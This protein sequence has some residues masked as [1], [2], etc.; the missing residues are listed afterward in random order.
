MSAKT[1]RKTGLGL[2]NWFRKYVLMP[3]V[4]VFLLQG[5]NVAAQDGSSTSAPGSDVQPCGTFSTYLVHFTPADRSHILSAPKLPIGLMFSRY[6]DLQRVSDGYDRSGLPMV[7][8]DGTKFLPAGP[9]DDLGLYFIVPWISR[10]LHI[11]LERAIAGFLLSALGLGFVVGSAGLL[12]GLRTTVVNVISVSVLLLLSGLAYWVGD[13]YIFEFASFAA[14]FPWIWYFMCCK[15]SS[16]KTLCFFLGSLG[17]IAGVLVLIRLGSAPAVLGAAGVLVL[18]H[19]NAPV[20]KKFGL[21][22]ILLLGFFAPQ[23][24]L[25]HVTQRADNFLTANDTSYHPGDNRHV[26]WHVAYIGLGFLSNPYVPGGVCDEVAKDKVEALSPGTHYCSLEYDRLLRHEVFSITREHSHLVLFNIFAKLG[27]IA[28]MIILFANVGLVAAFL[29]PKPWPV[30]LAFWTGLALSAG[31]LVVL[32]PLPMY[33]L[34]VITLAVVYGLISL[35]MLS[36]ADASS[37]IRHL[38]QQGREIRLPFSGC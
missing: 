5:V 33:S 13:I 23:L 34:G 36:R 7:A 20:N 29:Y 18:F 35:I 37:L 1:K 10:M 14:L 31:P 38:R 11:S 4:F 16:G 12:L 30:E 24:Y 3:C 9:S 19:L 28:G 6:R 25:R 21:I 17:V 26:F 32:A 2:N 27:I 22:A 15:I 8:Y